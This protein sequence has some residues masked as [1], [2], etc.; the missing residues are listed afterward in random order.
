V[1]AVDDIE[2]S[3]KVVDLVGDHFPTLEIVARARDVI[4][5]KQLREHRVMRVE[6]ERQKEPPVDRCKVVP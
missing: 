2:Q 3:L 1:L 6:R 5:W 4:H